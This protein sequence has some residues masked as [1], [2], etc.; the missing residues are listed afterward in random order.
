MYSEVMAS[1]MDTKIRAGLRKWYSVT[2]SAVV[3]RYRAVYYL[4]DIKVVL[5]DL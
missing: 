3:N 1:L 5:S 4:V 2:G